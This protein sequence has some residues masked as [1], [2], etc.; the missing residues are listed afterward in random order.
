[1]E[2]EGGKGR[3]ESKN[4]GCSGRKAERA[5]AQER[6]GATSA[7]RRAVRSSKSAHEGTTPRFEEPTTAP[8]AVS[9]EDCRTR[10]TEGERE[11][12]KGERGVVALFAAVTPVLTV[13]CNTPKGLI[14]CGRGCGK[15]GG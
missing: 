1:M 10:E 2:K 7:K 8:R 11:K 15:V 4:R 13:T 9:I 14:G 6:A 12:G 5:G 3:K